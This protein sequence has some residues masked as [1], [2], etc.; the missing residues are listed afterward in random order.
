MSDP[1][2]W[3]W[4]GL[5]WTDR[6]RLV[7][8]H[9]GDRITDVSIFGWRV[10]ADGTLTQTFDPTL[11]DPYRAKW[12]HLRFWL[13]FR[14]DGVASV[15]AALISNAAARAT[16]ISQ[17]GD[18][19]DTH[20]WLDGIDIDLEQG[21]AAA[22]AA[23]AEAL[24]GQVA[25]LAHGRGL[26]VSAAL[27][28]LTATG[29]VGGED[30]VRYRQ[31][32]QLMDHVSIM[33]YDFAWAGSA[34]GPI[35]P[36]FWMEEVYDWAA[37]QIS[38]AKLSM[39]L[40]VYAY[41]WYL[42]MK[43]ADRTPPQLRRG[44]SGTYY[45]AW[46]YFTGVQDWSDVGDQAAIG[47]LTYRDEESRSLWGYMS[48]YDWMEAGDY[49]T[50]SGVSA[51]VYQGRPYAVRYGL[52]A[53]AP[54]WTVADNSVGS[55]HIDYRV[56]AAPVIAADGTSVSPRR[57]Y[58]LTCE[59]IQREPVAATII[60]DYATD[61]AQLGAI[62]TQPDGHWA[63]A[64]VTDTYRQY[65]GTGTLRFDHDFGD[66]S[67]YAQA[68]FQ[69][70]TAGRF[71]L[72]VRGIT[73]DLTNT[74]TLRLMKGSTVLAT[75]TVPARPVGAA[76]GGASRAV[77]ALRVR[78]GSARVYYSTAETNIPLVLH[79]ATTPTGDGLVEYTA[80][81]TVWLDHTYLGD[82]WWYQP[83]E[84]L[85]VT[86]AGQTQT[87]GRIERTGITWDTAN[88]FRPTTD[89]DEPETRTEPVSLDWVYQH[90][91]DVPVTTGQDTTVTVRLIDHDLWLGRLTL[92]DMDG[93]SIVYFND[94]T[95]I[96]HWRARAAL[97]WGLQGI[98]LW[99]L[100]QEDARLW[101]TLAGGELPT[102]TKRLNS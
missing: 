83:R 31:L 38:P 85:E 41:F 94:A 86:V 18:V 1:G 71:G 96:N 25:D 70:A 15:F 101:D 19:L 33:S 32:G 79:H 16:L 59:V 82:G 97:D 99:S 89:V 43:P 54:Q 77:L 100:G 39:G 49:T 4:V 22:N 9:Y 3:V 90:Y 40:P 93:F 50:A 60:D 52:P 78:E 37:S 91:R 98:A 27:P 47:W 64:Q 7:L 92:G 61:E 12:P 87:L 74:G 63:F 13:A 35:S 84:A 29:S 8:E 72:T 76:A 45:A 68:R 14:N 46:Q 75:A 51:D 21:G 2:V 6:V 48:V 24:F 73:A 58:T 53:G 55:S 81:G 44:V 57:G 62:Y 20:P 56:H 30:W 65:R 66:A 10:N 80:T 34:P 28:A 88:R 26:L 102:A 23:A 42:H 11:L 95:A 17:L 69:F 5:S 67:L 36:G